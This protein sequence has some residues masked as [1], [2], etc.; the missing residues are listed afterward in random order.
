MLRQIGKSIALSEGDVM[1]HEVRKSFQHGDVLE[2][3]M[4]EIVE[5]MTEDELE[6]LR[7]SEWFG[8]MVKL[9]RLAEGYCL[10]D[11]LEDVLVTVGEYDEEE[12]GKEKEEEDEEEEEDDE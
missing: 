4:M 7:W 3:A 8:K 2:R 5:S 12:Y 9:K 1:A 11:A 10:F 6:E